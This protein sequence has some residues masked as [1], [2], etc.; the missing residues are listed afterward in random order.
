MEQIG[1]VL[2]GRYRIEAFIGA[3]ASS[4]VFLAEDIKLRRQVAV[5]V[6]HESLAADPVFLRRFR[7]E[8]QLVANLSHPCVVAVHDWSDEDTPFLVTEYLAGGSLRAMLDEN[9]PLD[10]SQVIKIGLDA[11]RGLDYAHGKGLVHRDIKPAN[12]LFDSAGRVRIADF[13]LARALAEASVTEPSGAVVGTARYAS[14]EQA[15]GQTLGAPSDV[16]S[17]ALTLT[18]AVQGSLPFDTDTPL[19]TLMSRVDAPLEVQAERCGKLKG[20]LERAGQV[21]PDQRPGAEDFGIALMAAAQSLPRPEP[22]PLA[23][24]IAPAP[25]DA[26]R[27]STKDATVIDQRPA[28]AQREPRTRRQRRELEQQQQQRPAAASAQ[29]RWP[30]LV[31]FV[32]LL[33]AGVGAGFWLTRDTTTVET[34]AV[35]DFTV[36]DEA[37]VTESVAGFW[38]VDINEDRQDN[39]LPGTILRQLPEVGTE[40]AEGEEVRVWISLGSELRAVPVGLVGQP[41]DVAES[42]IQAQGLEVG[43]V[44]SRNDETAPAGEVLEVG[45]QQAQLPT[46]SPVN[47]VVSLGP[48]NRVV[49]ANLVSMNLADATAAIEADRLVVA[50]VEAYDN[51]V[52]AG[53][54]SAVNPVPGTEVP[55]GGTVTLTIS[56]GPEPVTI[57]GTAGQDI[58]TASTALETAGLC[59]GETDGP[60]NTPVVGTDPPEG[61]VVDW[62]TCVRIITSTAQADDEPSDDE[63]N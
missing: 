45:A 46:G 20:P 3:G 34:R 21:E 33:A 9:G 49:A 4:R 48:A 16:Y 50:S 8:A 52:P 43:V 26:V 40:L 60:A 63:D 37:G 42:A 12:L 59:V 62:G 15:Q 57:P 6:L 39:T 17:L 53:I 36:M 22:L 38:T 14:P 61:T 11:A 24:A 7:E 13:G 58:L 29:R 10:P 44:S 2:G 55:V 54:V 1:R 47:L 41:R 19:G 51:T 27:T 30:W 56:L 5:K 28:P 18:E 31:A 23:G 35:P 25:E 32:G